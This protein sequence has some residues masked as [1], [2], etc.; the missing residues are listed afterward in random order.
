MS[1]FTQMIRQRLVQNALA[2]Y[3]VTIANALLP[4]V[5]IPYLARVLRPEAWGLVLFAQTAAIWLGLLVEYGFA[6]SAT[7]EVARHM[8]QPEK[9][10]QIVAEVMGGKLLLCVIAAVS[11]L[12]LWLM[13]PAFHASPLLLVGALWI[14]VAQG[15]SP[16]WYFQ[17]VERMR[18]P[19]V[20][21]VVFRLV[22]VLSVFLWIKSPDDAAAVLVFQAA[23]ITLSLLISL[24]LM[25]RQV[26][27]GG[28]SLTRA[29]E[30]LKDAWHF[31][32]FVAVVNVYGKAN[33]FILG[34]MTTPAAVSFYGGPER[35]MR[36]ILSL[37]GPVNQVL[38]PR[39]THLVKHDYPAARQTV[40]RGTVMV[41]LIGLCL[42]LSLTL[43][44][45]WFV[46]LLFGKGYEAAVPVLRV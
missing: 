24:R 33:S 41:A 36:G 9:L 46:G 38:Y 35:L 16:L 31:F 5:L 30:T 4:L 1:K 29:W 40:R 25:Y 3:G 21:D 26:S 44:A 13:I 20:L 39:L 2:L 27:A 42:G 19:A 11:S 14:A 32:L 7:R 17:G 37:T 18:L 23:S 8:D 45:P 10:R 28:C 43:A 15:L 12:I 34:L 6:Y 22:F